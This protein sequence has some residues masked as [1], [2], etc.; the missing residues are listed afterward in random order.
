MLSF[1]R[2]SWQRSLLVL[3]CTIFVVPTQALAQSEAAQDLY[4][5]AAQA[6]ARG[7][8]ASAIHA[9]ESLLVKEPRLPE[10]Y[11]NLGALLYD[12]AQYQ[13]AVVVLQQALKLN[14]HL[15]SARTILG[16]S[17]LALGDAKAARPVLE[18]AVA[19]TPADTRAQQL[20][21]QALLT[22][23][24]YPAAARLLQRRVE[25]NPTDQD[26][27]YELGRIYLA[28]SQQTLLRAQ[29]AA[30]DSAISHMMQ[31]EIYEGVNNYAFAQRE[32]LAAVAR[33]PNRADVH[34]HLGNVYWLQGLWSQAR[35]EFSTALDI[36]PANCNTRWKA[37]D[38]LLNEH[39]QTTEALN[40]L[41]AAV[42][43]CPHLD[44]ARVDRA[45]ALVDLQRPSDALPDLL[46]AEKNAPNEPG[47]HFLLAKVY[48]ARSQPE[49]AAAES[50]RF[51]ALT[52]QQQ[53]ST[54]P[55]PPS[56]P[57]ANPQDAPTQ[58]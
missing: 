14:P 29:Q 31:G 42:T 51:A 55:R 45:K 9:Y 10:A 47:I 2:S 24:D 39:I 13:R 50:Q 32:Y 44:Q 54:T 38:T 17:L 18:S 41:D 52:V 35:A 3:S 5:R 33:A 15:A 21:Q 53:Q 43:A 8:L 48:R 34:D 26:A 6:Q 20:L 25:R 4:E 23:G 1:A 58:P 37:A 11:N 16:A 49:L 57:G 36:D 30:P 46:A 28:M 12:T 7:D 19:A 40:L 22:L 27:L 56:A